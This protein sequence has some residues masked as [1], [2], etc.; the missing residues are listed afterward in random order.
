MS[1]CKHEIIINGLCDTCMEPVSDTEGYIKIDSNTL[2]SP[3]QS[4]KVEIQNT[5]KMLDNP[6][7]PHLS[8]ILDLDDTIIKSEW[9]AHT[10]EEKED[11]DENDHKEQY[12]T[13]PYSSEADL[14]INLR[15]GLCEFL[16]KASKLFD[17]HVV[18]LSSETYATNVINYINTLLN[19]KVIDKYYITGETCQKEEVNV[20]KDDEVSMNSMN[21]LSKPVETFTMY[22][23]VISPYLG[24]EDIQVVID[25]RIDVWDKDNVIQIRPFETYDSEDSELNRVINVLIEVHENFFS[26]Y[27][28]KEWYQEENTRVTTTKLLSNKRMEIMKGKRV[29]FNPMS[30]DKDMMDLYG[31]GSESAVKMFKVH[32]QRMKDECKKMGC[33]VDN[34]LMSD[35]NEKTELIVG[36]QPC[37]DIPAVRIEYLTDCWVEMSDVGI[38][39]YRTNDVY[40]IVKQQ[41]ITTERK[42]TEEKEIK[43]DDDDD[44]TYSSDDDDDPESVANRNMFLEALKKL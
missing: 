14:K 3:E 43:D 25:D 21:A 10:E 11:D 32:F 19:E 24:S 30:Y 42:R 5:K 1:E 40:P 20:Y 31:I 9:V 35:G 39:N 16:E 15:Y 37:Y 28:N 13:V 23:K 41:F 2:F 17:I 12:F 33:I 34:E 6:K 26:E 29:F 4:K 8:L 27:N 38:D 44:Y 7:A 36:A 18:T 22:K